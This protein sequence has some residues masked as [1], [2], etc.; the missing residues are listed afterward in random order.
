MSGKKWC[1]YLG[2]PNFVSILMLSSDTFIIKQFK[3]K[4]DI[5]V[6]TMFEIKPPIKKKK[7]SYFLVAVVIVLVQP[8][9]Q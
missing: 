6:V 9:G 8:N 1:E 5:L 4:E 7:V 3:F 2:V